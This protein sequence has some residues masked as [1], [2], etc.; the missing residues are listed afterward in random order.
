MDKD[1]AETCAVV[2]VTANR[3]LDDGVHRDWLR[4]RYIESLGKYASVECLILPTIDGDASWDASVRRLREVMRRLDGLVLTG[5]ESNLDP[6]I[7]NRNENSWRR[8]DDDIISGVRDRPR[9]RLSSAALTIAAE[10]DMPIL[11][12]CRGLQEMNV[13]RHGSLQEDMALIDGGV[14]HSENADL[15]R[16]QQYLPVHSVNVVAGG[17]LSTIFTEK[18]LKVNSLHNQGVVEAAPDVR[19]EAVADDGAIEAL[20]YRSARNFQLAVQWHPEW[21]AANDTASQKIFR[22]FGEA[23]N[24]YKT[25]K[26]LKA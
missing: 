20:S 15:P 13:H 24:V 23:C 8:A 22:K 16:D 4:R 2:G 6:D 26:F 14:V 18:K 17:I 3:Y 5:D 1:F 25:D 10:L 9:D 11:G 21:H 12:I 19:V 7:F